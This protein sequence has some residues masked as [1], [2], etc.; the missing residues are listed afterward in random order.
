MGACRGSGGTGNRDGDISTFIANPVRTIRASAAEGTYSMSKGPSFDGRGLLRF[1]QT[2][3]RD[4]RKVYKDKC[5]AAFDSVRRGDI[6]WAEY[7][8]ACDKAF[9]AMLVSKHNAFLAGQSQYGYTYT[10]ERRK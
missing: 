3:E 7:H 6:S 1:A 10:L 4:A 2:A 8:A 5:K 9:N